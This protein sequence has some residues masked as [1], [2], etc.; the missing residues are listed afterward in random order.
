MRYN[1]EENLLLDMVSESNEDVRNALYDKYERFIQYL[2]R[3]YSSR[4]YKL[5]LDQK[6]LAQEA[7]VA[8][9]DALNS[10]N[11]NKEASFKTFM[12]LC[13]ERRLINVLNKYASKKN[14]F[15]K[16]AL[17]LEFEYDDEASMLNTF[18]ADSSL[19]PSFAY[20]EKEELEEL[21][22]KIESQ[23]SDFERQVYLKMLN[24]FDYQKIAILLDK[25]PKQ[26]DN[27]IQRI[28]YKM[29]QILEGEKNV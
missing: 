20:F 23:L 28:R 12:S 26:I 21:K 6:D 19:D 13:I 7:N 3:K 5:G 2:V 10:Y 22:K 1:E 4:A 29:R 24:G 9:V 17:S 15:E 11:P 18:L 14:Q 16:D 27:T 25:N 8:F